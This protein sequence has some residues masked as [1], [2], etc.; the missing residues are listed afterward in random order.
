M[1]LFAPC[2]QGTE[3]VILTYNTCLVSSPG[4]DEFNTVT[5]CD[6]VIKG[7]VLLLAR[8]RGL[9][10]KSSSNK[11]RLLRWIYAKPFS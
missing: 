1:D 11:M 10:K 8:P 5:Y 9:G 4:A 2:E 7:Q 6:S 3:I